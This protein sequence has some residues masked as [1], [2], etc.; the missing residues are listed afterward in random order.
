MLVKA[1][2]PNDIVRRRLAP[3]KRHKLV[4]GI[5]EPL[6]TYIEANSASTVNT[7]I[8]PIQTNR[9]PY[10][11]PAGPPLFHPISMLL[12]WPA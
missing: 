8:V 6:C 5:K 11:T 2:K 1:W 7:Q 9:K 12:Y 4:D 10:T 3:W